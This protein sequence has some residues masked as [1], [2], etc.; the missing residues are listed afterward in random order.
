MK[1]D[2]N[3]RGR[4]R[5]AMGPQGVKELT[6]AVEDISRWLTDY[7]RGRTQYGAFSMHVLG[8]EPVAY[9]TER[10]VLKFYEGTWKRKKNETLREIL[11][12]IVISDMGHALRDWEKNGGAL[13]CSIDDNKDMLK[14]V[15]EAT[16]QLNETLLERETLRK[17]GYDI[18]KDKVKD[19]TE[20]TKYVNTMEDHNNYYDIARKMRIGITNVKVLEAELLECLKGPK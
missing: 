8:E 3:R 16:M 1:N 20:L 11:G 15:E 17:I 5:I 18:A 13:L 9:F 4:K 6:A 14:A 12:R 2:K 10:A 19:N 7:L